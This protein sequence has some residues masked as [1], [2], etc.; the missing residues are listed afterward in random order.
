MFSVALFCVLGVI[1]A[2]MFLMLLSL[3]AVNCY[4]GSLYVS[5]KQ[6]AAISVAALLTLSFYALADMSM[7]VLNSYDTDQRIIRVLNDDRAAR[8]IQAAYIQEQLDYVR[9]RAPL[10]QSVSE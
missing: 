2:A 9:R 7:R 8:Q 3:V 4:R 1:A 6:F 10:I 5:A